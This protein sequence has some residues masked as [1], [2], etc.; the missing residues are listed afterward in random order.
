A[1]AWAQQKLRQ[2]QCGPKFWVELRPR[3]SFGLG[4]SGSRWLS[5]LLADTELPD[6][7][8]VAIGIMYLQVVQQA[9][10]LAHEHQQTT[11]GCVILL[12]HLE[13]LG[14]FANPL[15]QNRDLNLRRTG[16]RIV[17]T[18]ALD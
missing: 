17:C 11:P 7:L 8:T 1:H 3:P 6:H 15:A 10:A 13:M 5:D 4:A 14:Q 2:V 18:E 9:A 12:V 16:V